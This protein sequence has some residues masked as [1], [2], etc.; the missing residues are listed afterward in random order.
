MRGKP[1]PKGVSGNPKG[2]PIGSRQRL[3]EAFISAL[4]DDFIERGAAVIRKVAETKPEVYL[5]IVAD[6]LPKEQAVK[7]DGSDAFLK[8]W[9]WISE[10]G[11][12]EEAEYGA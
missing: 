3:S 11:R 9:K 12:G 1:F 5:R 8:V 10:G 4:A 7:M 2:R 6:L